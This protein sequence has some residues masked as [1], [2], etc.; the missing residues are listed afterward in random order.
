LPGGY[1][2]TLKVSANGCE[3]SLTKN[4]YQFAKPVSGFATALAPVCA[5]TPIDF[6]N[7]STI[8]LGQEGSFWTYGDGKY[9]SL[10]DG[11]NSY[12]L[13]GTYNVKL[14]SVSEFGCTD[15]I[16]KQVVIKPAPSPDFITNKLCSGEPTNFLNTTVETIAN[17]VY[18]WTLSD[19]SSYGTKNITK[20]WL[21]EGTYQVSL[22]ADF[23][24]GCSGTVSKDVVVLIQPKSDFTVGDICSGE[25]ANYVNLTKG[26]KGYIDYVW[27]LGNG[28]ST[29]AAPK[30]LYAPPI[31]TTYT[32]SLVA[33]YKQGCSDT[34]IK[35]MTVSQSPTCDFA[36]QHQGYLKY[37][38]TPSNTTYAKYEWFFG[39]GG[40]AV[41]TTPN[42]Q[43]AY[44]SGFKVR[45][46][47][48]NAAGCKC[49]T[50]KYVSASLSV[51]SLNG[52]GGLTIYPNP[53]TGVFT[54]SSGGNNGMKI[55]VFNLLGSRIL[56]QVSTENKVNINLGDVSKGIYLVKV[57]M[58]GV[59]T[60]T[61]VT[62]TD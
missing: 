39:E 37:Q 46:V 24:N 47:A 31:T 18:S 36:F 1:K 23:S 16:T 41:S 32:I 51:N 6:P 13:P 53:N 42:Y 10:R 15:S 33:S 40:T 11:Y 22:Q 30:R 45:M 48:T 19:N 25:I 55:E 5:F 59:T 8:G 54:I 28:A 12:N 61:K 38:F 21:G 14:K 9:S 35:T 50:T 57:T 58:D 43:Y 62:V 17:P 56:S 34:T 3:S 7:S 60:T 26:D 27:D 4:A 29:D 44:P 52:A 20:N 49:E 2:V